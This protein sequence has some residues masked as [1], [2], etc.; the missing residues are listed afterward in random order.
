MLA[1]Y[2]V[3]V[4][5]RLEMEPFELKTS[6][7]D[8]FPPLEP[9]TPKFHWYTIVVA[10]VSLVPPS[11]LMVVGSVSSFWLIP[12]VRVVPKKPVPALHTGL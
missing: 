8:L 6:E 9:S 12:K 7:Y 3:P 5:V 1:L 10:L 11:N 4:C 2:C